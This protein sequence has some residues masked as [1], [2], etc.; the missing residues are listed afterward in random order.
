MKDE[1]LN[2][3]TQTGKTAHGH[4]AR[5]DKWDECGGRGLFCG[6]GK[7]GRQGHPPHDGGPC[8]PPPHGGH[9]HPHHPPFAP[10]DNSLTALMMKCAHR[11][12]HRPGGE[13]GRGQGRVLKVLSL[14]ESMNQ[15]E[16]QSIL[17]IQP[18]S[19]S[20][21]LSKLEAKGF[22][23]REKSA[24]DKRMAVVRI[25]DA[26]RERLEE[27]RAAADRDKLFAAL[28]EDEQAQLRSLLEKLLE[29]WKPQESKP[30]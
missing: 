20:E 2:E 12:G 11:V 30:E 24:E 27:R 21:I 17:D 26:G 19:L 22:I 5:C 7:D 14:A 1:V 10:D 25:T 9:G 13:G 4:C 6:K 8:P 29:S 16:L 15:R 28:S 23:E 3:K 18:G